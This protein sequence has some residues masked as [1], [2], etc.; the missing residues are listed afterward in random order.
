MLGRPNSAC[1][2]SAAVGY[3][4]HRPWNQPSLTGHGASHRC[5]EGRCRSKL[6]KEFEHIGA[7]SSLLACFFRACIPSVKLLSS[8]PCN[9][10]ALVQKKCLFE[11]HHASRCTCHV[12]NPWSCLE[13]LEHTVTT[14][15]WCFLGR[16][17]TIHNALWLFH[18][19]QPK[20]PLPSASIQGICLDTNPYKGS[21]VTA[22][23]TLV[24]NV[25]TSHCTSF[26]IVHCVCALSLHQEH[27]CTTCWGDRRVYLACASLV[28]RHP[29]G[30]QTLISNGI[31]IGM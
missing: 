17:R 31:K 9:M 21:C 22:I 5:R 24:P 12:P 2:Q 14:A 18:D 3:S 11:C 6:P 20:V 25:S 8:K 4:G 27:R 19:L 30:F 26:P 28:Q 7:G 23:W 29:T 16:R 15:L 13:Y 10:T 1:R